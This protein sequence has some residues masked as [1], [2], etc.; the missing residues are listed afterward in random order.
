MVL[1]VLHPSLKSVAA[2]M[3]KPERLIHQ[4]FFNLWV[5]QGLWWIEIDSTWTFVRLQHPVTELCSIQLF[6]LVAVK[7]SLNV[8][9]LSVVLKR[10]N[11]KWVAFT[12]LSFLFLATYIVFLYDLDMFTSEFSCYYLDGPHS[13]V[14]PNVVSWLDCL[15]LGYSKE[16]AEIASLC[17]FLTFWGESNMQYG[18]IGAVHEAVKH[19]SFGFWLH[20]RRV[21]NTSWIDSISA[22]I[23]NGFCHMT[24]LKTH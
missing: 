5:K 4:G 18:T 20:Y 11:T 23:W 13:R 7:K 21:F 10:S 8:K 19:P 3:S 14:S 1:N 12:E 2:M 15:I 24:Q 17:T 22:K 16:S 9:E 6:E